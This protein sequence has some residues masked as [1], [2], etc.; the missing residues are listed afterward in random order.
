MPLQP[1][2]F[3]RSLGTHDDVPDDA[4]CHAAVETVDSLVLA[5]V[6]V[7]VVVAAAVRLLVC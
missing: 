1:W 5:V 7:V 4:A 6:V 3:P 2:G